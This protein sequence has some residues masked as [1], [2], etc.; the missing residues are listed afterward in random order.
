MAA[1]RPRAEFHT[2]V[3]ESAADTITLIVRD[4]SITIPRSHPIFY[5]SQLLKATRDHGSH[6]VNAN[7]YCVQFL[8][9]Y[10][11]CYA[12]AFSSYG[13]E[14]AQEI[15]QAMLHQLYSDADLQ[16]TAQALHM[17]L[18]VERMLGLWELDPKVSIKK[19]KVIVDMEAEWTYGQAVA[20]IA[21]LLQIHK[22]PGIEIRVIP[23]SDGLDRDGELIPRNHRPE[24]DNMIIP[25]TWEKGARL[26][27][28]SIVIIDKAKKLDIN[29][30]LGKGTHNI[31]RYGEVARYYTPIR[32]EEIEKFIRDVRRLNGNL[33][34]TLNSFL[35]DLLKYLAVYEV[36]ANR[37]W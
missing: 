23:G 28:A 13:D 19:L 4:M 37:H 33:G 11:E 14:K 32:R 9:D 29:I 36:K 25:S 18:G 27:P 20:I 5:L 7:P 8:I 1:K 16:W 30:A 24:F 26:M 31:V 6:F 10:A 21:V 12:R 35:D 22:Y 15:Q 3:N 2:H 17:D 34:D